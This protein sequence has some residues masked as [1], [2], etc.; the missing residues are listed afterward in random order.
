MMLYSNSLPSTLTSVCSDALLADVAA[1]DPLVKNLRPDFFYPPAS[2][3]RICTDDCSSS[4]AAWMS[5]VRTNCGNQTILG[6]LEVEAAAVYIPGSLQYSFQSACLQ[7]DGGRYCGPVAALA[8]AFSDPG[9]SPFNYISNITEQDQK[10]DDCDLCIV[11]RLRLRAGSPYFDGPIVASQSMYESMTSSCSIAGRP[12]TKSTLDY[13]TATPTPTASTCEGSTYTVKPSDDCYTISRNQGVGTAW[14]LADNDLDAYCSNFPGAD[15]VLCITNKCTT[16]TVGVNETCAAIASA[17]NITETQFHAW[18]PIINYACSNLK[19]MNGSEVCVAAPGRKFVAPTDTSGLPPITPTVPAA[20]PTDVAEGSGEK[21]CG[22]W[23]KV[24]KGDYCNLLTLKFG[25][26]LADFLFL[27]TGIDSNCTNLFAEESYCVQAVGDINTY[28]GR[29]GYMTITIDPSATFTGVPF[30]QLPDATASPYARLYTPLPTAT[31]TRDDCVHYFAGDDY[32]VNVT[33]SAFANPCLLAVTVYG[34]DLDSFA[35]WNVGLGDVT[36]PSCA[37]EKGVRYCGSW[38]LQKPDELGD[39]PTTSDT[40]TPTSPTP[41]APTMSGEPENCNKWAVVEDGVTCTDMAAAAGISLAQ[42]LAW[43]P[44]VSD[45]CLTNYWLGEAYC[46]G[47]SSTSITITS[48]SDMPST[49]ITTTAAPTITKPPSDYL[50]AGQPDNC[51][52][53]DRCGSGEYCELLA[54]RNGLTVSQLA[55]LNPVLGTAGADCGTQMWFDYYYC[56]AVSE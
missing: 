15:T 51:S 8:A 10:P 37:F 25:I 49:T 50:Q 3:S 4:L 32:Q 53:W 18:N 5:S 11:E 38:Y 6:D 21:P 23:Y 12:V 2:L 52:K 45:D 55:A 29:P 7:D 47:V 27:N 19:Q 48:T 41:P 24:Q 46:V 20:T 17:A 31:G 33:G 16:V 39:V 43:N 34:V 1:C 35:A 22:R 13:F 56:V 44:A 26:S 40:G 9:V 42:F 54:S 14:L 36:S 28:S 30:T